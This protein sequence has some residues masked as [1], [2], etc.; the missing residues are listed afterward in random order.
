[1]GAL[2]GDF[3][4]E[5]I[6]LSCNGSRYDALS[7]KVSFQGETAAWQADKLTAVLLPERPRTSWE[8]GSLKLLPPQAWIVGVV[9]ASSHHTCAT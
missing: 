9:I 7:T 8:I 3:P 6:G 1:M 2:Q 4:K 5:R